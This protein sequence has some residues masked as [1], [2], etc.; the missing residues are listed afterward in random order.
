MH[1]VIVFTQQAVCV[2]LVLL[3]LAS[4][5]DAAAAQS[6]TSGESVPTG[7]RGE[8]LD[9]QGLRIPDAT[10][11][12][13][14]GTGGVLET[15]TDENGTFTIDKVPAGTHSVTVVRSGFTPRTID[16]VHTHPAETPVSIGLEI[17]FAED[18]TV[19]GQQQE[20]SIQDTEAS[21][22]VATTEQLEA[23]G[24]RNLYQLVDLTPNVAS[25]YGE[26]GFAIRGIDQRGLG[27]GGAGLLVSV[28]VDG[29]TVQNNQATFFGPYN[30][31]DMGQVEIFRGPQSTQQGRNSLAGAIVME[32]A[33]P[34][35]EPVVRGRVSAGTLATSQTSATVNM[36]LVENKAA[37]RVSVDNR[38]SDGWVTNPTRDENDYDFREAMNVRTKLRFD[39]TAKFR[40][41]VTFSYTDS[42]G[43]EDSVQLGTFPAERLNLSNAPAE[44]GSIHQISTVDLTY[45]INGALSVES[46]TSAYDHDYMREEDSDQAAI[47][48]GHFRGTGDGR[49]YSQEVRLR[50]GGAR[51]SGVVGLYYADLRDGSGFTG[52]T[53]GE[54]LGLPPGTT[55]TARFDT[56][57]ETENA[58][59]FGEFDFE[60]SDRWT[61]TLGARYDDENRTTQN[62]QDISITPPNP[63][64][65]LAPRREES[66]DAEYNA[67]L[68][69]AA[70][71]RQWSPQVST[72]FTYQK[73]YRSGGRSVAF[74]S[75][76]ISDFDPEFTDNYEFALR[77][78]SA[79]GRLLFNANLFYI[80]W[81]D[82]QVN[83][84]TDL[85]N[86][87]D[88]YTVNA[89]EST[90]YGFETQSDFWLTEG[91]NLYGSLGL[92]E[93]RFD[94][95]I[96]NELDLSGNEFPYAPNWSTALGV[97]F[98]VDE[99][100]VG[101]VHVA[102]QDSFFS[103]RENDPRLKVGGRHLLN[104]RVGYERD[105]WGLFFLGRNL[106]NE[107][108]LHQAW[109][110]PMGMLM[111]RSGEPRTFAV[112]LTVGM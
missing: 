54:V 10:V 80:D 59:L 100:W 60:L 1:R 52:E 107:A 36:P 26:K 31:W 42:R 103:E 91:V 8:V 81:H 17:A 29:A 37:F 43:G 48:T 6:G 97:A 32:G 28:K 21:V 88:Q 96:D 104:M 89:G 56:N 61:A 46:I 63:L 110:N 4:S 35:Y 67:F 111:G 49:W 41:M 24:V 7:L 87:W 25:A 64:F 71:T 47:H 13:V 83:V 33:D 20:R 55:L 62:I 45:D 70:I 39:P 5:P 23:T 57:E 9:P 73:G 101:D 44:E 16:V 109:E 105:R 3:G 108:F 34:V 66:L 85:G 93:T 95:F 77:A 22:V 27:G 38:R 14:L 99:A 84:Y 58:A 53:V 92:N 82:Q 90:V 112:E 18:V 68:P 94:E 40:G 106:L 98:T 76:Q 102:S 12:A 65:P 78:R 50:Y 51:S 75:Q 72:S 19:L 30:T 11:M 74:V 2:G 86:P 79:D 15:T 69:K